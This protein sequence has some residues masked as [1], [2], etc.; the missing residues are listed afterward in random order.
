M[1]DAGNGRSGNGNTLTRIMGE[2]PL[3][4]I[5]TALHAEAKPII[6]KLRLKKTEDVSGI[7]LYAGE[8]A[9]L[10]VS[11]TGPL[12]AAVAGAVLLSRHAAA[13]R[14]LF[15]NIGVCG[16]ADES[17]SIGHTILCHKIIHHDSGRTY[18][19]DILYRHPFREGVL[20]TFSRPVGRDML[21]SVTGDVVDMEAAGCFEAAG[22]FLPP[23]RV[24]CVKIVSDLLRADHPPRIDADA[25][26]ALISDALDPV[27]EY[28][29]RVE[30]A[31]AADPASGAPWNEEDQRFVDELSARLRLTATLRQ[32]LRL[33]AAGY[34]LRHGVPLPDPDTLFP[35]QAATKQEGKIAFEHVARQ[36]AGGPLL[37]PLH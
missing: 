26:T 4:F 20:E 30:Q 9:A 7:Q 14:D 11:G 5:L 34:K 23:D 27:L 24:L 21:G 28:A 29:I 12:K 22:A 3:L 2:I 13:E 25:V 32:R 33:L 37:P 36:L 8:R 17:L 6:R 18:Y 15:L 19:P 35:G 31:G 1:E 16:A 10:A